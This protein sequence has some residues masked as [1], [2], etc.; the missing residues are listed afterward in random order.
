MTNDTKTPKVGLATIVV[1][2]NKVLLGRRKNSSNTN[3][4]WQFTGGKLE[5]N[6]SWEDCARRETKEETN[7]DIK[8]I[9]FVSATNDINSEAGKHYI[10][11]FMLADYAG[12]ELKVMEPDKAEKE[13]S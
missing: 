13:V 6:E 1:K 3:G 11:I 8:N 4:L 9:R 2:D 12:G 7:L 10:T 5:F